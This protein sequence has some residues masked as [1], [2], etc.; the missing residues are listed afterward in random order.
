MWGEGSEVGGAS[1]GG[2]AVNVRAHG[3]HCLGKGI[4]QA[5]GSPAIRE[6]TSLCVGESRA[7]LPRSPH[8]DSHRIATPQSPGLG[9][10]ETTIA[11][12]GGSISEVSMK[13]D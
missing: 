11:A 5:Q 10:E 7:R 12:Q 6:G 3:E 4:P 8:K 1:S 2:H 9:K 13:K